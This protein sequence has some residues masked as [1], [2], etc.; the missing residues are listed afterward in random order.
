MYHS[1]AD[2]GAAGNVRPTRTVT[3][4]S[5]PKLLPNDLPLTGVKLPINSNVADAQPLTS[6]AKSAD[7]AVSKSTHEVDNEAA[8]KAL[9]SRRNEDAPFSI[10]A[11]RTACQPNELT[12]PS[13][14]EESDTVGGIAGQQWVSTTTKVGSSV[15]I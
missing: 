4:T 5:K 14:T 1:C 11:I 3:Y 9:T 15:T 6:S 10:P 13:S 7:Q 12:L 8:T 2:D